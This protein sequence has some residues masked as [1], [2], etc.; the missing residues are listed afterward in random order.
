MRGLLHLVMNS[1]EVNNPVGIDRWRRCGL[2]KID[3]AQQEGKDKHETDE[4]APLA[5]V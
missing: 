3:I 2:V 1:V 4:A 5:R